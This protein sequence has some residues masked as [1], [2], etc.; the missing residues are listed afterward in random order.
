[1]TQQWLSQRTVSESL[2]MVTAKRSRIALIA[3]V[4]TRAAGSPATPT[5]LALL[6]VGDTANDVLRHN[7][8]ELRDE[9]ERIARRAKSRSVSHDYVHQASDHLALHSPSEG[10][11]VQMAVGGVLL[12]VAGGFGAALLITPVHVVLWIGVLAIL[13]GVL[14]TAMFSIGCALKM[15]NP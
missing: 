2:G 15:R 8:Q 13:I 6:A 11:D 14:G 1:M 7:A 5:V 3:R 12:G 9:A 10:A 4:I